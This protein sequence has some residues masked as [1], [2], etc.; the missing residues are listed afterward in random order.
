MTPP[1]YYLEQCAKLIDCIKIVEE[2]VQD[3]QEQMETA[4][5]TPEKDQALRDRIHTAMVQFAFPPCQVNH[6]HVTYAKHAVYLYGNDRYDGKPFA[7]IVP[8]AT[9]ERAW[10]TFVG[11]NAVMNRFR[12]TSV[13]ELLDKLRKKEARTLTKSQTL[14][15]NIIKYQWELARSQVK[16]AELQGYANTQWDDLAMDAFVGLG[17]ILPKL[18]ERHT[19][20]FPMEYVQATSNVTGKTY[21]MP[22]PVFSDWLEE[23]CTG[24]QK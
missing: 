22:W 20:D 7:D 8:W 10:A 5:R 1:S 18:R 3:Y 23:N 12:G 9:I 4:L 24:V 13:K 17:I 15:T 19:M 16:L 21:R 14:A 2:L 11:N 6:E